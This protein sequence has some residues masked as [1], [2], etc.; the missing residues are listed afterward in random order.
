VSAALLEA[1]QAMCEADTGEGGLRNASSPL[2]TGVF[3]ER[4]GLLQGRP[5]IVITEQAA[6]QDDTKGTQSAL[7]EMALSVYVD[8]N[9]GV[10]DVRPVTD[11]LR[12]VLHRKV[13]SAI[14]GYRFTALQRVGGRAV[15][16]EDEAV[17][18][19]VEQYRGHEHAT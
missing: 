18:R 19:H 13:P 15:P 6:T 4:A 7:V 9:E 17:Y 16:D 2:V 1:V 12:S 10:G 11:R 8:A 5:Y 14:T 3:I